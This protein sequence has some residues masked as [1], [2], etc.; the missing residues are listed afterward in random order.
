MKFE[1]VARVVA[2]NGWVEVQR[3]NGS[4]WVVAA[5]WTI[6]TKETIASAIKQ[7]RLEKSGLKGG[8]VIWSSDEE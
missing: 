3:W 2:G 7:A 1:A 5:R 6:R 4:Q 8:E